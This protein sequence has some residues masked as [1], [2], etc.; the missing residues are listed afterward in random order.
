MEHYEQK[1]VVA[2]PFAD[3]VILIGEK[4]VEVDLDYVD[5][6]EGQ[7]ED[8]LVAVVVAWMDGGEDEIVVL[9]NEGEEDNSMAED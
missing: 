7:E 9:M 1:V 6:R 2:E 8:V 4:E 5:R 3:A